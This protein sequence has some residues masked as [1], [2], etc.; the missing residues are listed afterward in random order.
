MLRVQL[1]ARSSVFRFQSVGYA[2]GSFIRDM[3]V[4]HSPVNLCSRDQ[5]NFLM[6]FYTNSIAIESDKNFI[7]ID[8]LKLIIE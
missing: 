3:F 2:S 4:I 1:T 7:K 6:K 8:W 5:L